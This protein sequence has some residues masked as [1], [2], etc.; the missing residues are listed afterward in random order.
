M[1]FD[2]AAARALFAAVKSHAESLAIF[3][4]V[5]THT[6][7]NAPPAGL[8]AWI[9]LGPVQPVTSSGLA[10]VSIQV[11]LQIYVA[12]S[13]QQKPLGSVDPAVLG[14]VSLLMAAYAGDFNLGGL[15]REVSIFGGLK[16]DPGYLDFEG[17]PLRLVEITLP[18]IVNDAWTE[19][20]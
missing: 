8:S 19:V 18:M 5:A 12:S 10:A 15:V 13:L 14:A 7:M 1:T 17:K 3:T 11:T 2:A 4:T 20:P 16:A 6:P 9:V